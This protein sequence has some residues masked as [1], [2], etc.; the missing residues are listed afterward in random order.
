MSDVAQYLLA[1][2]KN[3]KYQLGTA[4]TREQF[5]SW[6]L[7]IIFFIEP[8]VC[9]LLIIDCDWVGAGPKVS[10]CYAEG[11]TRNHFRPLLFAHRSKILKWQL[12]RKAPRH[13]LL[14]LTNTQNCRV[15]PPQMMGTWLGHVKRI[16]DVLPSPR[17]C[18]ASAKGHL[19]IVQLLLKALAGIMLGKLHEGDQCFSSWVSACIGTRPQRGSR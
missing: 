13:A 11:A 10:E 14:D 5:N 12:F 6:M 3:M 9:S 1:T 18:Q 15:Y 16:L 2:S 17:I 7:P 4:P 19:K 8:L